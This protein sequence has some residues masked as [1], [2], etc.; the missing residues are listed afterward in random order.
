[1]AIARSV[2]TLED[3]ERTV[4]AIATEFKSDRIFIIGSQSILLAWPDAPHEMRDSP[5]IDVFPENARIWEIQE[6]AKYPDEIPLASEHINALFGIGSQFHE[7]HGF[8]I[9]AWM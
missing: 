3:L 4:R 6:K 7:T 5:E 9:D 1:M 8:Y 2:R